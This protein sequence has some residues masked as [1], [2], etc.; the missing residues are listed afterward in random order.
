[1]QVKF[2]NQAAVLVE[3]ASSESI[4]GPKYPLARRLRTS[5]SSLTRFLRIDV[6]KRT[7][8]IVTQGKFDHSALCILRNLHHNNVI[9]VYFYGVDMNVACVETD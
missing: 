5:I 8:Y 6:E 7:P 1:M 3:A 9:I 4:S 2:L